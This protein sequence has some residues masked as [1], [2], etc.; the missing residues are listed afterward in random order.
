MCS[1]FFN[2]PAEDAC[3]A[4]REIPH[5]HEG[6]VRLVK[7]QMILWWGT[8][9]LVPQDWVLSRHFSD[10]T[11]LKTLQILTQIMMAHKFILV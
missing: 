2:F 4:V 11:F 10:L 5:A 8:G 9:R 1:V 6:G 3:E 7:W